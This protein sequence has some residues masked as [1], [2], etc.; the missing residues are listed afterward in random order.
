MEQR[1]EHNSRTRRNY[2]LLSL[3]LALV[4]PFLPMVQGVERWLYDC[5]VS[6][7]RLTHPASRLA[8]ERLIIVNID[9]QT[10]EVLGE[11]P[12]GW[13]HYAKFLQTARE[14][15]ARAVIFAFPFE[16]GR[17][18]KLGE[19]SLARELES[20]PPTY[21]T[22]Y[23]QKS[24]EGKDEIKAVVPGEPF[25]SRM[26]AAGF[27]YPETDGDGVL[28]RRLLLTRLNRC[29]HPSLDVITASLLL[30]VSPRR[31]EV[32]D[33][34]LAFLTHEIPM[35]HNYTYHLVPLRM[36]AIGSASFLSFVNGERRPEA[37]GKILIVG[38]TAGSAAQQFKVPG[39]VSLA[40]PYHYTVAAAAL[41]MANGNVLREAPL[42]VN[43]ILCLI[44]GT[45][46]GWFVPVLRGKRLIRFL[47]FLSG[48]II[49]LNCALFCLGIYLFIFNLVAAPLFLAGALEIRRRAMYQRHLAKFVPVGVL[50]FLKQHDENL[51]PGVIE[52]EAVV[53]FAD[54]KGFSTLAERHAPSA[55]LEVLQEYAD[56][57]SS[58]IYSN[59]GL[60]MDFQGDGL[61]AVFG[62]EEGTGNPAYR[63]VKT[64]L[65]M[66]DA[67][68]EWRRKRRSEYKEL[69][70][71]AIGI[72]TG[73][74]AFG[75]LGR[76]NFRQ[77]VG[78][79][80]T[81]NLAARLQALAK[82]R[83]C[84]IIVCERTNALVSGQVL[85][86]PLPPMQVKGKFQSCRLFEV[87]LPSRKSSEPG[88]NSADYGQM[89]VFKRMNL[90]RE[91]RNSL[92]V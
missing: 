62:V 41:D 29:F 58:I 54:I 87:C 66:Q 85:T 75:T 25:S 38:V 86:Q 26:M 72:S 56:I 84:P 46:A 78:I 43:L 53:L 4:F 91:L 6:L 77:Y 52:T 60:I 83:R 65:I 18:G 20:G 13:S 74:V 11:I 34:L 69:F 14:S 17:A 15:G 51:E 31:I 30:G 12:L 8:T 9:E 57:M 92:E 70:T 73:P 32:E 68:A 88:E 35:E 80:D 27:M 48:G 59:G 79:G 90:Y 47:L 3:V 64:A 89:L 82:E 37:L 81:V 2:I 5:R 21:L 1:L 24:L 63:A 36:G 55:I 19:E 22:Y 61:M 44:P 42:A 39:P 45:L 67:M 28:R 71:F 40:Q 7:F 10:Q 49:I 50:E 33:S 16:E 23:F 76:M